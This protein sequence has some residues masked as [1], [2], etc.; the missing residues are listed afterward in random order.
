MNELLKSLA[1]TLASALLGPLGGVAVA[2]IGKIFG[3]D[4][5]T[6]ESISKMF[7]EGKLTT[8]HLAELKK[9]ELEYLN[10]EKERGFRYSELVFKDVASARNMQIASKSYVP[11]IL[12][13]LITLGFFGILGFM[14]SSYYNSSEPLLV[15]LGSLGTAWTACVSYWFGSSSGS[16]QKTALLAQADSVSKDK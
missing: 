11:A 9:L 2:S 16:A 4:G 12:T 15:M 14:M 13:Y 3:I 5:A 8:E 1:P 6:T 7:T 10:D